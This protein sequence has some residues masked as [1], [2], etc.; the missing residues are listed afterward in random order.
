MAS[1]FRAGNALSMEPRL[2]GLTTLLFRSRQV[3][4]G[5]LAVLRVITLACLMPVLPGPKGGVL[6]Q[7][8]GQALL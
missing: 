3:V 8:G 6:C 1:A 4:V 7:E 2:L 5:I